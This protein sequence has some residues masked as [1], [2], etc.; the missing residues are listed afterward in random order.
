MS[1]QVEQPSGEPLASSTSDSGGRLVRHARDFL[2]K[3]L[4]TKGNEIWSQDRHRIDEAIDKIEQAW[5]LRRDANLAVQLATM[6]DQANQNDQ[7][8]VV[9]REA[10]RL[11][12]HHALVRHHAAITLLRHGDA[13]DIRDFFESVLAVDPKDAFA[14]F[15][16][17]MLE[18]YPVWVRELVAAIEAK[19]DGRRPFII[20]C[21]VWGQPFAENFV[22]YLCA[23]LLSANNLPA[24]AE[25]CA[26]HLVVFTTAET[27]NYLHADPTFARV[28]DYASVH[29]MHYSESQAKYGPAM[30][31]H[32]GHEPVF[33]SKNSLAF[34][35]ARNC[36]FVLMSCAHY[37]ALAAGRATDA[38]VSGQVA[39]TILNDGA[40]RLLADQLEG[41]ADAILINSMQLDGEALRSAFESRCRR[42]DGVL[43]ITPDEATR[44][45]LEHLPDYNFATAAGLP[46][47]PLRTC[48][49]VGSQAI[50]VHGNHYHPMGLRPKAFDH[51]L[52]LS[53]DPMDSRFV[54]RSSLARERIHLVQDSSIV[55]LSIED[56]PLPEQLARGGPL[57]VA[58][59]AFWLWGYWGRL[60]GTFFRTPV[61][62]GK[63]DPGEWVRAEKAAAY[64]I[65]AIVA[66]AAALES[67]R[68]AKRSWRLPSA[69]SRTRGS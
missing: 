3:G 44:I 40:L 65:D 55:G 15:T 61:R 31:A 19:R 10:F 20:S 34:Y 32:Y 39:D 56:G 23:A 13:Q 46:Q 12:P 22:R 16:F 27:E 37:V 68:L 5:A 64:L 49:R 4:I 28:S 47:I 48:W 62:F 7:A 33:Y 25:R 38:F 1:G 53:I 66:E 9:L 41:P 11:D 54:D 60:R 42:T 45:V 35:Y 2:V 51:P 67:K 57:S 8:L 36:K 69:P 17:D 18:A 26:V 52:H 63:A 59:M 30:E 14:R 58:D 6:Y 50:L 24:L 29:F 21:P 43:E